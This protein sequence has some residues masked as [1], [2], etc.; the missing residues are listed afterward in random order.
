[1][2]QYVGPSFY[3]APQASAPPLSQI[4]SGEPIVEWKT[5]A[6]ISAAAIAAL[7]FFA[8]AL[9]NSVGLFAVGCL[10]SIV[11]LVLILPERSY[12]FVN[13]AL[14][15]TSLVI[16]ILELC[17]IH[18]QCSHQSSHRHHNWFHSRPTDRVPVGC[19]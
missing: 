16:N 12:P 2:T 7:S 9:A 14:N 13:L 15:I 10:S 19:W 1:M 5:I 4:D 11:G 6:V 17:F 3:A 8:A 18:E